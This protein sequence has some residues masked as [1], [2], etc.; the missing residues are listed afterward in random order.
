MAGSER[1]SLRYD[2]VMTDADRVEAILAKHWPTGRS[3]RR[4]ALGRAARAEVSR[5][6]QR[7]AGE[8]R[9]EAHARCARIARVLGAEEAA[10]EFGASRVRTARSCDS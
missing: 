2:P 10:T 1:R 6:L 3:C 5:E 7:L 8:I 9:R 4:R